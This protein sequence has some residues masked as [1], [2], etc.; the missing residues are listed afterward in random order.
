MNAPLGR[1]GVTLTDTLRLAM[2]Q[3]S[4]ATPASVAYRLACV[5]GERDYHHHDWIHQT[6]PENVAA[7]LGETLPLANAQRIALEYARLR[8]CEAVDRLQLAANGHRLR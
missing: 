8:R 3:L 2:T 7:V 6:I 4:M 1:V 5:Q